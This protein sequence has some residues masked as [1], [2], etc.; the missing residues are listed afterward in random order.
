M[1]YTESDKKYY[2]THKEQYRK[3]AEKNRD[4]NR[5]YQKK[6]R[7][8]HKN[9]IWEY[10][11]KNKDRIH[12]VKKKYQK[13]HALEIKEKRH[14]YYL[15]N[16]ELIITRNRIYI[17]ENKEK[18][19]KRKRDWSNKHPEKRR[20]NYI[21]HRLKKIAYNT[22]KQASDRQNITTP[23]IRRYLHRKY[24]ITSSEMPE[25]LIIATQQLIKINRELSNQLKT[26]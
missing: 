11:E 10:N 8:T 15:L 20:E 3:W 9:K 4:K 23:Y 17:S 21:R 22:A 13:K 16:L 24:R 14:L 1:P 12:E 26:D 19:N 18:V 25:G 2:L 5:G 6:Y 7:L